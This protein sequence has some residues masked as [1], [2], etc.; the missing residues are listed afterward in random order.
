MQFFTDLLIK[1]NF[2]LNMLMAVIQWCKVCLNTEE[3]IL[4]VDQSVTTILT[5]CLRYSPEITLN[6]LKSQ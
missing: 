4:Y 2:N 6:I 1:H 3:Q 5:E